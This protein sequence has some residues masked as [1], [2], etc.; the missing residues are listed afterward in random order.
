MT[1]ILC[2][3]LTAAGGYFSFGLGHA[4]WLAW[5][6]PVPVL[7]LTLGERV[8]SGKAFLAAWAAFALGLTSLER[9]YGG[10]FPALLVALDILVPA[11]LF[12]LAASGARRVAHSLGPAR[13]CS[14]SRR[15]GRAWTCSCR[16]IP[17]PER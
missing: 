15:C 16:S 3:I 12:A 8:S 17:P 10:V 14:R 5:L 1:A 6:A 7:W 4:W 13:P 2:V 9:A 11:L